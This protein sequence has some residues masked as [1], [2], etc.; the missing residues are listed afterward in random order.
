MNSRYFRNIIAGLLAVAV[1]GMLI[2]LG[3]LSYLSLRSFERSLLPELE[4]KAVSVGTAV[5]AALLR[6][7]AFGIDPVALRGVDAFFTGILANHPEIVYLAFNDGS[8]EIV[9]HQGR[10]RLDRTLIARDEPMFRETPVGGGRPVTTLTDSAYD[11]ALPL[12]LDDR[13]MGVLHVGLDRTH[14]RDHLREV[15]FDI[16]TVLVISLLITYELLRFLIALR[17]T[18]PIRT[19]RRL[20]EA[21]EQGDL[22]PRRPVPAGDRPGQVINLLVGALHT[23]NA[24]YQRVARQFRETAGGPPIGTAAARLDELRER[25]RLGR[26]TETPGARENRLIAIRLPIFLFFFAEEMSRS[27]LPLHIRELQ[28]QTPI[29]WLTPE[30][31]VGLPI[32]LFMLIVALAQPL[33]GGWSDR[34]GRRHAFTIGALLVSGG[35]ILTGFAHGLYDLL[36][37]RALTAVGYG[38]VFLTC[39]AY[40]ADH[41]SPRNRARGMAVFVGGIMAAAICGPAIGGIIADRIGFPSTFVLSALLSLLSVLVI[42]HF[43]AEDADTHGRAGRR[44]GLRD[45]RIVLANGRFLILLMLA[46]LPAKIALTGFLYYL[47]P[48]YLVHL[49]DTQ[50]TI[51]RVIMTYGLAMVLLGPAA[52]ALA[53]RCGL[54]RTLVALGGLLAGA[55]MLGVLVAENTWTILAAVLALG[56]AHGLSVATQLALVPDLCPRECEQLGQTTVLGV[57]RLFER[58]GSAAGPLIAGLLLAFSNYAQ[59]TVGIGILLIVTALLFLVSSTVFGTADHGRVDLKE[60]LDP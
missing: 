6:A 11:T 54:S 60:N 26:P 5:N 39:Q 36:L 27:F 29:P 31:A 52:A 48:L 55:G 24:A 4:L 38:L 13:V 35:L 30:V 42:R 40:V 33:G 37:W 47:V 41:A 15:L 12:L 19:I 18:G 8:G 21:V 57:F 34:V 50:S 49:G 44:V 59:T 45:I 43:L 46:A 32:A 28:E 20:I 58:L 16:L 56:L 23:V 10:E 51:G 7:A 1:G 14:V 25:Y 53:D 9:F 22:R 3:T 2:S 17:I